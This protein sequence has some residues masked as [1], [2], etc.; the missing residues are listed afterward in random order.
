MIKGI[1]FDFD[2]TLTELTIDFSFVRGEI[3]KVARR[4]VGDEE[5]KSQEGQYI[6]EMINGVEEKLGGM[7]SEFKREALEELRKLELIASEGKDVY[8]YTREVLKRLKDKGIRVGIFTRTHLDVLLQVFPD[9]Y[10]FVEAIVT[11]DDVERVKPH[12]DH[13]NEVIRLLGVRPEEALVVG[14]HPTDIRSGQAV[15]AKSAAVLTGRITREIFEEVG[16]TYILNDVRDVLDVLD[17]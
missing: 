11:R 6:L 8:P 3:E 16:A 17:C 2:G 10:D 15:S 5:I 14:D 4:Y 1:I 12:P 7:V 9:I 13:A